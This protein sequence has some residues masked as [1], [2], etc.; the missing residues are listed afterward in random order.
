[1]PK[2]TSW[3]QDDEQ[4]VNCACI[5]RRYILETVHL[6]CLAKTLHHPLVFQHPQPW[7]DNSFM[8]MIIA[9]F[10]FMDQ[11]AGRDFQPLCFPPKAFISFIHFRGLT[12]G[13]KNV[14]ID[15]INTN[16]SSISDTKCFTPVSYPDSRTCRQPRHHHQQEDS[17]TFV[18][19]DFICIQML[20]GTFCNRDL[21]CRPTNISLPAAPTSNLGNAGYFGVKEQAQHQNDS[22]PASFP[23]RRRKVCGRRDFSPPHLTLSRQKTASAALPSSST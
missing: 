10:K 2:A 20:T 13:L 16:G 18:P 4:L 3:F 15:L 17:R 19:R 12:S 22:F 11:K 6:H 1:M 9:S 8:S 7:L 21:Q 23:H 14:I 5:P